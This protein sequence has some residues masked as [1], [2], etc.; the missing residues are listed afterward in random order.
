MPNKPIPDY[1]SIKNHI[2]VQATDSRENYALTCRKFKDS[3]VF[4]HVS[5]CVC[6]CVC[7]CERERE[8]EREREKIS[9][10][11]LDT[12]SVSRCRYINKFLEC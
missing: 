9:S 8:R 1:E 6:V 7:V 5:L 2:V 3:R 10:A 12:G 4:A 11:L